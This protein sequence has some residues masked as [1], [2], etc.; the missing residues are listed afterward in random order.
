MTRLPGERQKR[1]WYAIPDGRSDDIVADHL[2]SQREGYMTAA[3]QSIEKAYALLP[4]D[5]GAA[6]EQARQA[7]DQVVRAFWWAE[8]TP[9]ED[10]IHE[11]MH[12]LGRWVRETFGCNVTYDQG[13][14]EQ[15]C[16]IAIG[17]KRFGFSVGFIA[18]RM[19]SL[20][21][22]DLSE[23][24]HMPGTA[25]LVPGGVGPAGHCPVCLKEECSEHDADKTYRVGVVAQI[26]EAELEEVSIVRRP[27]QPEARLTALPMP[28]ED[29]RKHLGPDFEPGMRVICNQCLIGCP[30]FTELSSDQ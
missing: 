19:C 30:G 10:A 9:H 27:A 1:G 23:C 26:F 16:P 12:K 15:R 3:Q 21:G 8:D 6:E 11:L 7:L 5:R 24:P 22:D 28:I 25:Y 2:A 4:T 20:C 29:L 18:R 14:Y 13:R 17:H